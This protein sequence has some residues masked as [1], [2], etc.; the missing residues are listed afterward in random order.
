[1]KTPDD[2]LTPEEVNQLKRLG[3]GIAPSQGLEDR[4]VAKMRSQGLIRD[5]ANRWRLLAATAAG[6]ILFIAGFGVGRGWKPAASGDSRP[7]FVLLLYE[8]S[9]YQTAD[10]AQ[11]PGRVSEYSQ[12]ARSL[13]SGNYIGGEKLGDL[14]STV[15]KNG[16][17]G[18]A[19][20]T[21]KSGSVAGYFLIRA[22]DETEA[23]KIAATCP[24]V[25]YGGVVSVR[26][27]ERN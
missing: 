5:R 22:A 25:S 13:G 18:P 2:E 17:V 15:S 3:D 19:S 1:M 26:Q 14:E 7:E 6:V 10:P 27:L 20:P 23:A 16:I 8:D 9:N 4:V 12:W 11:L 21:E 24:H